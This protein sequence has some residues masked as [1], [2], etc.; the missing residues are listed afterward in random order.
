MRKNIIKAR[1]NNA[2]VW[3]AGERWGKKQGS[4]NI[5]KFINK[6]ENL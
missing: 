4:I 6:E 1:E 3:H 2:E 5:F